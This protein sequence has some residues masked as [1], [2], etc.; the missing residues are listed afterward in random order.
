MRLPDLLTT[1]RLLLRPHQAED[2][3]GFYSLIT[4][5]EATRYVN[6]AEEERSKAQLSQFF[7]EAI[8]SRNSPNPVFGL[9]I[10]EKG[11][12]RYVGF[13]GL[14]P[15]PDGSGTETYYVFD[16]AIWG[17]GYATEAASR[18]FE[19]AFSVLNLPHIDTFLVPANK[20]SL[21]MAQ[22]LGMKDMGLSEHH[23]Y[24]QPVHR[25]RA[26]RE[27]FLEA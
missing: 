21:V 25:F 12:R 8:S 13:C 7:E 5:P 26:T 20:P 17:Q 2:F 15:L 24:D 16:P 22:R 10:V 3:E 14:S 19:Y 18:L 4:N 23:E 9:A 27:S 6:L 11:S 1:D